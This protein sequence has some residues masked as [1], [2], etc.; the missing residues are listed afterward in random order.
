MLIWVNK[1]LHRDKKNNN[2][3]VG[4]F[5]CC[6]FGSRPVYAYSSLS[7][8]KKKQTNKKTLSKFFPP[9][10]NTIKLDTLDSMAQVISFHM[11][12]SSSPVIH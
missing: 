4:P 12:L 10:A 7:L 2:K 6:Y 8:H 5:I 1:C 11:V 9:L 3:E